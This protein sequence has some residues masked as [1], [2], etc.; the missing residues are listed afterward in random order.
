MNS[1][2]MLASP[3]R[4]DERPK[5]EQRQQPDRTREPSEEAVIAAFK[6]GVAVAA[7]A[8]HV[9]RSARSIQWTLRKAG[10]RPNPHKRPGALE[11]GDAT[12]HDQATSFR[13]QDLAFQRAMAR[14][15]AAGQER[16]PMVGVRKDDRPL[17]ARFVFEPVSRTSGCTSPASECADLA[18]PIDGSARLGRMDALAGEP[19][20]AA[21]TGDG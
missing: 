6:A 12:I 10:L 19:S 13:D 11:P 8:R 2:P 15:I 14:A 4:R 21:E 1:Q 7:I 17:N 9:G 3:H 18:S 16:P 5:D 20:T